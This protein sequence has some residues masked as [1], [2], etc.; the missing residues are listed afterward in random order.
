[1]GGMVRDLAEDCYLF[2]PIPMMYRTWIYHDFFRQGKQLTG[3]T[4]GAKVVLNWRCIDAP[5][6]VAAGRQS[7]LRA[8]GDGV[9]HH[10]ASRHCVRSHYRDVLYVFSFNPM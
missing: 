9:L 10:R 6:N 2:K 3:P 1:M 7:C 5:V 4:A 8:L